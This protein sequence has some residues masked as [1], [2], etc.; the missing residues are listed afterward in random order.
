[1]IHKENDSRLKLAARCIDYQHKRR[2]ATK[3]E[4]DSD[5]PFA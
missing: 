3:S 4:E 5:P 1:M 2:L